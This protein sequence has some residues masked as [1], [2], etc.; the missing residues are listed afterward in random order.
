M[1]ARGWEKEEISVF[2][3][4]VRRDFK[5][6]RLKMQH[7]GSELFSLRMRILR[8]TDDVCSFIVYAQKPTDAPG[9]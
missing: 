2:L 5:N 9:A 3:V 4:E 1:T 7:D 6:P 8:P